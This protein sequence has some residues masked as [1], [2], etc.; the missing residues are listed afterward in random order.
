MACW[1]LIY[2]HSILQGYLCNLLSPDSPS[3]QCIWTGRRWGNVSSKW[4]RCSFSLSTLLWHTVVLS[5]SL[6]VSTNHS[7]WNK[8]KSCFHLLAGIIPLYW[9]LTCPISIRNWYPALAYQYNLWSSNT[10]S[11]GAPSILWKQTRWI[12]WYLTN[13]LSLVSFLGLLSCIGFIKEAKHECLHTGLKVIL[14]QV[15]ELIFLKEFPIWFYWRSL[16][17]TLRHYPAGVRSSCCSYWKGR[18]ASAL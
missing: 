6:A 3:F 1:I 9:Y 17:P 13:V 4:G 12:G 14:R 5:G 2:P 18:E 10:P 15:D 7:G 8:F 11:A 16:C